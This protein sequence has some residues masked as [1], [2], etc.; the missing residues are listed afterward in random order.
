MKR[1][2]I[3]ALCLLVS[4][5]SVFAMDKAVGGGVLFGYT[6]QGGKEDLS[7]Y[8]LG[9]SGSAD[10]SFDRSSFGG[11]AFFG[12]GQYVELNFAFMY[13]NGEVAATVGGTK[14]TGSDTGFLIDP[15]AA[16][17]LGAYYKYPIPISDKVV[18]FPTAGVDF[19]LNLNSDWIDNF[20]NDLW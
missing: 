16:V 8:G 20:W 6:F 15:T 18:F 17:G 10:W 4:G 9:L 13:K 11:F 19:E 1:I 14:Y 3:L 12:L 5:T 7:S 2:V